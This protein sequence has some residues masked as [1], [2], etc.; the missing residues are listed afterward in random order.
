LSKR[1]VAAVLGQLKI[2][3]PDADALQRHLAVEEAVS[4]GTLYTGNQVA[5]LRDGAQTLPAMFE[6][7]RSAHD[8]IF[9]EYYIFENIESGG[10]HLAD[11][12]IAKRAQGVQIA[13]MYD[14]VGSLGIDDAF[15]STLRDA[16]VQIL[17]FNPVNPLRARHRWSLNER[18]HRKILIADHRLAIV[19]GINMSATYQ[20]RS[21][22]SSGS[23]PGG[24]AVST[25]R[26]RDTD[27]QITGP[28]VAE[29]ETL[30]RAHWQT[31]GGEAL[32]LPPSN[33]DTPAAGS[34][35][36]RIIG[37]SPNAPAPRYYA[38]V[39]SAIETAERSV[40]LT[41]AYFVPT[42]QEKS[43][44]SAAAKRGVDVRV[45]VP[46]KSDSGPALAIQRSAYSD[47]LETGVSIYE[48][49]DVILHS[50]SIIV[51]SV[52]SVV[53]SSNF[54]HRSVLYNDEVDAVTLGR[55]TAQQLEQLFL[56]DV[57]GAH[58][59]DAAT[60]KHRSIAQR[61][62]E[63]FWRVWTSLL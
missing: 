6:A 30:F 58:P 55:E 21:S 39:V 44:L 63:M 59:I 40:W 57:R 29:L 11:L 60:W 43:A 10:Q 19:G 15:L 31:Q 52:W 8:S 62:R 4:D 41:A 7:I 49:D 1:Q 13:L 14:S 2:Q 3:T 9:L 23:G 45:L 47:L 18:D 36:V 34:Q 35:V 46:S 32:P 61:A 51:D 54:D 48:R 24:G 22:G 38:A 33:P 20:R 56:T 27:V 37:S 50:K 28:A 17:E 25:L 53:G 16:G 26:W 12:L 42:H 5:T